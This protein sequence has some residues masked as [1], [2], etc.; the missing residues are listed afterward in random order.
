V[1]D[2]EGR[3]LD[4]ALLGRAAEVHGAEMS[5][6]CAWCGRFRLGEHWFPLGE[7]GEAAPTVPVSHGIC[8]DCVE[9]LREAGKS[10]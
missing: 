6:R 8:P 4:D 5:A 3:E 2:A 1:D 9:A 7:P 10:V